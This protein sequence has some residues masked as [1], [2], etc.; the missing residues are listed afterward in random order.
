MEKRDNLFAISI[1]ALI[2]LIALGEF[3][4]IKKVDFR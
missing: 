4:P 1:E 3:E 2:E